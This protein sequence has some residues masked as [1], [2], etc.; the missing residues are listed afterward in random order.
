M[1]LSQLSLPARSE[2][3][4]LMI[5]FGFFMYLLIAILFIGRGGLGILIEF[6][7]VLLL[8]LP[9]L[10][11]SLYS[12]VAGLSIFVIYTLSG[13]KGISPSYGDFLSLSILMEMSVL[14]SLIL[15]I[16]SQKRLP[17]LSDRLSKLLLLF[18]GLYFMSLILRGGGETEGGT[19]YKS[20]ILMLLIYAFIVFFVDT[21]PRYISF[22]RSFIVLSY[23]LFFI[24][25]MQVISFGIDPLRYRTLAESSYFG[26]SV[27]VNGLTALILM[28][29]PLVYYLAGNDKSRFW[30][31]AALFCFPLMLVNVI[32]LFSR[33]GFVSL[34]V[35]LFL[36]LYKGKM[37]LKTI[38]ILM[39]VVLIFTMVPGYYWSRMSTIPSL[40]VAS[41][42][43]MKLTYIQDAV[44]V[45]AANP[46]FGV[47]VG[48]SELSVHNTIVQV[49]KDLGIP[50]MALFLFL[51][52]SFYR[53]MQALGTYP[54]PEQEPDLKKLSWVFIVSLVAYL[55]GGLSISIPLF[56]PFIVLVALASIVIRIVESRDSGDTESV[57]VSPQILSV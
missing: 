26:S 20:F 14:I 30:K 55:F 38:G 28:M 10:V 1:S 27:D 4:G 23:L 47:G 3:K 15:R 18:I 8:I 57:S 21:I 51:I 6:P 7:F 24:S 49:G 17:R 39:V 2:L 16:F 41:G 19:T 56:I 32:L 25:V 44:V 50:A 53:K 45:I 46:I 9:Y 31:T 48:R 13:L 42:L 40:Q 37:N 54:L 5:S 36:L 52:Y 34:V 29:M 12:P 22:L 35:V 33:N 43:R 11:L